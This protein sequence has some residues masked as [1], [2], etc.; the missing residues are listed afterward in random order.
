MDAPGL[1]PEREPLL[2][3]E[4]RETGGDRLPPRRESR[5]ARITF[6]LLV[7]VTAFLFAWVI[8][9][10]RAPLFLAAVLAAVFQRPMERLAA[11]LHGRRRTASALLTLGVFVVIVLPLGSIGAFAVRESLVGLQYLRD[12]LGVQSVQQLRSERLP[13]ARKRC[14]ITCCTSRTSRGRR[15]PMASR[16]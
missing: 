3:R 9:P 7:L 2:P 11:L 12:E 5:T 6:G 4:D 10:F 13:R 16:A 8:W 14:S 15:S 1:M